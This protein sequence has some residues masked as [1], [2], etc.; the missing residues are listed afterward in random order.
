[1]HATQ[2]PSRDDALFV[3][4]S[5]SHH[6]FAV[7][8]QTVE[9]MVSP[10]ARVAVP[11]VHPAVRGVINLRGDVLG[12][13]CLRGLLGVE[14]VIDEN[15]ALADELDRREEDHVAWLRELEA[16]CV[17]KRPFRLTTDPH[18]CAFG[19]WFDRYD[20]GHEDLRAMVGR[21]GPPHEA[22]HGVAQRVVELNHRGRGDE[23][24][25][26]IERTRNRELARL[27]RLFSRLREYLRDWRR[28]I[29]LVLQD[30]GRL[31]LALLVDGVESVTPLDV[32]TAAD[33]GIASSLGPL[34]PRIAT[35]G[36]NRIVNLLDVDALYHA[37]AA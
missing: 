6:R 21:L 22:I 31:P 15:A 5:A 24:L 3:V 26:V 20:P 30:A 25:A 1:M 36:D 11:N 18:A 8:F 17:E 28:E 9:Q 12:L 2:S 23:A 29:A 13:V 34:F 10:P 19:R 7:P 14:S 37:I 33:P 32:D 35:D 27:V 16:S 4:F